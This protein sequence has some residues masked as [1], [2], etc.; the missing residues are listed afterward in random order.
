MCC[1]AKLQFNI[2]LLKAKALIIDYH[3]IDKNRAFVS[4]M[5]KKTKIY[6]GK[7]I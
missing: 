7:R 2:V 3:S 5:T 4:W 6:G 1:S